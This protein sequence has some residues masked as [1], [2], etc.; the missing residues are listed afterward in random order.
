MTWGD[1]EA[2]EAFKRL[3]QQIRTDLRSCDNYRG[4]FSRNYKTAS[5]G[6]MRNVKGQCTR[7]ATTKTIFCACCKFSNPEVILDN[8]IVH[9]FV[10]FYSEELYEC[11]SITHLVSRESL[12][13][14]SDLE[15]MVDFQSGRFEWTRLVARH[16]SRLHWRAVRCE[17][18][19][20]LAE[21]A[22]FIRQVNA[23][24]REDGLL[25]MSE[26][27]RTDF[28]TQLLPGEPGEPDDGAFLYRMEWADRLKT[29]LNEEVKHFF[30]GIGLTMAEEAP[31]YPFALC[32][33][34]DTCVMHSFPN[35]ESEPQRWIDQMILKPEIGRR[36][37]NACRNAFPE[38]RS[39]LLNPAPLLDLCNFHT[40]LEESVEWKP[41]PE[42]LQSCS[43]VIAGNANRTMWVK[44]AGE[45]IVEGVRYVLTSQFLG[46]NVLHDLLSLYSF[47]GCTM[48][49]WWM[50]EREFFHWNSFGA[51][52]AMGVRCDAVD[53]ATLNGEYELLVQKCCVS[54]RIEWRYG[55]VRTED[56]FAKGFLVITA[57]SEADEM[58]W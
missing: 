29:A 11:V 50:R 4:D 7:S 34:L 15:T 30:T 37:L 47:E 54:G 46:Q 45:G 21:W 20:M 52:F 58:E 9:Y 39:L 6:A 40:I 51:T 41:S 2:E 1:T 33:V 24:D 25:C 38:T 31:L 22:S 49:A 8:L 12:G 26:A 17:Q 35:P 28:L 42:Q 48:D 27:Q 13:E 5:R 43:E 57:K 10:P 32:D 23:F 3:H 19:R 55:G 18:E 53:A 44:Y 16:F 14:I 56:E 36:R